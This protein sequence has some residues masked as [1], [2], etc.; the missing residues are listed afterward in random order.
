MSHHKEHD[1][2]AIQWVAKTISLLPLPLSSSRRFANVHIEFFV[3]ILRTY[4][5]S[6]LESLNFLAVPMYKLRKTRSVKQLNVEMLLQSER[7]KWLHHRQKARRKPLF[8]SHSV[9]ILTTLKGK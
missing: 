7:G 4:H 5:F 6:S 2:N 8:P 9:M 1:G 3:W